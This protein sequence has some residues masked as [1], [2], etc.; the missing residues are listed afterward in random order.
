MK[1]SAIWIL[2][3]ILLTACGKTHFTAIPVPTP[4]PM[5]VQTWQDAYT[6]FLREN[7]PVSEV[8]S[9][10]FADGSEE[11]M[12]FGAFSAGGYP[13]VPFFYL[14]DINNDG[15]PVL[16]HIDA[17]NGYDG[18]VYAYKDDSISKVGSI[19]FYPFGGLGVPLDKTEGLYSDVGYKGHYGE[20]YLYTMDSGVLTEQMVLEYNN[21]PELSPHHP[22][23]PY[24]FDNFTPLDYY[25]VTETNIVKAIYEA[26]QVSHPESMPLSAGEDEQSIPSP[27]PVNYQ[28][29]D[30]LEYSDL[31]GMEFWFSSGAG[32]WRTT[33]EIMPDGTFNG[34][35]SDSDVDIMYECYFN[36]QFSPL[37]KTGDYEYSMN[38]ET[39]V[40]KGV[41]GDER[42]ENGLKIITSTPYG[43]DDADEFKLYLPGKKTSE[44]PEEFL[45]WA[46]SESKDV[47]I[48]YGLYNV[49]GE[50]GFR[51]PHNHYWG[52]DGWIGTYAFNEAV[53][54]YNISIY[55][56]NEEYFAD[57]EISGQTAI[58]K[59][60]GG[61]ERISLFLYEVL[62]D[63]TGVFGEKI[64]GRMISFRKEYD[65]ETYS[66]QDS[67][68]TYWGTVRPTLPENE[69][70]NKVYFIKQD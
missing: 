52:T 14:Y 39:L 53:M 42:I 40:A 11:Q 15:I 7:I 13:V 36:G 34:Y 41:K 27:N 60:Y 5:A 8:D 55:K 57:V 30:D 54:N 59:V 12:R 31:Y 3:L 10:E 25:E 26:T 62:T 44:L 45:S 29:V 49:R 18:D 47:L 37:E 65:I 33:L 2:S 61:N 21:Q 24:S 51:L 38:C 17:A 9:D 67:F 66:M 50:Q 22:G 63:S 16:I 69:E 20:I 23:S 70:S 48:T 19:K 1:K 64:G 46:D 35:F 6:G 56:E 4:S 43:F 58:A 68:Y 28:D 32:A